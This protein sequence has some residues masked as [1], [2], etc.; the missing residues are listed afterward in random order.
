MREDRT[1]VLQPADPR[2]L[3]R[4]HR[5][6]AHPRRITRGL[7]AENPRAQTSETLGGVALLSTT[8]RSA[9]LR[10]SERRSSPGAERTD[11]TEESEDRRGLEFSSANGKS[12]VG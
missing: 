12:R 3:G 4:S 6:H 9:R 11:A 8:S 2:R 7:L 10:E 1:A 5:I